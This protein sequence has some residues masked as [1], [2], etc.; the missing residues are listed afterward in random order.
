MARN[1]LFL[2]TPVLLKAGQMAKYRSIRRRWKYHHIL[3][4]TYN[5]RKRHRGS[6]SYNHRDATGDRRA[7]IGLKWH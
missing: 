6:I 5:G 4:A 7:G 1:E 2:A 3:G